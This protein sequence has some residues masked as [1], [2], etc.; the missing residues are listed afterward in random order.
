MVHLMIC[1]LF[2]TQA[3]HKN[4]LVYLR[5]EPLERPSEKFE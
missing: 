1:D 2:D 5:V 3:I 4:M